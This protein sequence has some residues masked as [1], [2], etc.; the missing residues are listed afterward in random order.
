MNGDSFRRFSGLAAIVSAP[1]A[2]ASLV[3]PL[4]AVHGDFD[5]LSDLTRSL[6][7]GPSVVEPVRW[8][9][10]LDILGYYLLLMPA[11]AELGRL[12]APRSARWASASKRCLQAYSLVGASGAAVL[13]AAAP[14]VITAYAS[15]PADQRWVHELVFQTLTS[16]VYGGLWN[17]L[18]MLLAAVAWAGFAWLLLPLLR[19]LALLSA[20]LAACCLVDSVGSMLGREVAASAGLYGYLVLAPCWAAWLGVLL[21]RRVSF[22]GGAV[23]GAGAGTRTSLTPE[24]T[25]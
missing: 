14:F 5:A 19:S 7:A 4:A 24:P 22:V 20:V 3:L 12:L 25:R 18:E 17:V 2:L 23:T 21:L 15:A 11:T 10:W 6:R 1:L 13:G 16:A 8:S 9:M